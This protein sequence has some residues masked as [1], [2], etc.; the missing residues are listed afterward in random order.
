MCLSCLGALSLNVS[1]GCCQGKS[2]QGIRLGK[3]SIGLLSLQ[4][5]D[6]W[7]HAS[8]R[9]GKQGGSHQCLLSWVS[10]TKEGYLDGLFADADNV[11]IFAGLV[12]YPAIWV[13]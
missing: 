7:V 8:S 6:E 1:P 5:V 10:H 2:S 13:P 9:R 11:C 3:T 4:G 12:G